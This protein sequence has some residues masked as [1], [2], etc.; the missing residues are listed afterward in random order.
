MTFDDF[1]VRVFLCLRTVIFRKGYGSEWSRI[2][3]LTFISGLSRLMGRLKSS[4]SL[5][6]PV[7]VAATPKPSLLDLYS[8]AVLPS[9]PTEIVETPRPQPS[10]SILSRL[11][12][13]S[14]VVQPLWSENILQILRS[15][16]SM[17]SAQIEC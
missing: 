15:A 10:W 7:L 4:T 17:S 16:S 2:K 11:L 6:F 8:A 3:A 13:D 9:S 5:T 14:H 12:S 1:S